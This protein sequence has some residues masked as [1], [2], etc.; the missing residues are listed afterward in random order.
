MTFAIIYFIGMIVSVI[1]ILILAH[2]EKKKGESIED[3]PVVLCMCIWSWFCVF[4]FALG[5]KDTY[6]KIFRGWFKKDEKVA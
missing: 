5:Y 1:L 4:L 2:Y 3:L 6:K